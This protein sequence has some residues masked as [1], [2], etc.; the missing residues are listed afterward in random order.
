MHM[1]W[2]WDDDAFR[3]II[4]PAAAAQ[5]MTLRQLAKASGQAFDNLNPNK[6]KKYGRRIDKMLAVA[7]VLRLDPLWLLAQSIK[8]V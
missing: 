3:A 4:T 6:K 1:P 5:G 8:K 2:I 7:E